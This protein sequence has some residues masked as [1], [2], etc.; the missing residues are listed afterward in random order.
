MAL[1]IVVATIPAAIAGLLLESYV[2][3]ALRSPKIIALMLSLMALA[4]VVAELKG[5]RKKDLKDI[6]WRDAIIVGLAQAFALVPGVSRSGSTITAALFAG[7]KRET[8]ARFSF[9]LS[10]PIIAGAVGKKLL[11]IFQVGLTSDQLMPFIIDSVR[12][13]G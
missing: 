10:A 1:F 8:A 3:T 11:D 13:S 4:L 5:R 9:Y 2:E 6:G 12:I 7:M